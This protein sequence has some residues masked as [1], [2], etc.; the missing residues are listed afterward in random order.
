MRKWAPSICLKKKPEKNK[1]KQNNP[2]SIMSKSSFYF[3]SSFIHFKK[4]FFKL[5]L[6]LISRFFK[7]EL[8]YC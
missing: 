1:T 7:S 5:Y 8:L 4:R 2:N 3:L 6:Y